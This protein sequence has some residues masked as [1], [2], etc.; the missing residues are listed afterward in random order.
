MRYH[1]YAAGYGYGPLIRAY[2]QYL[3][4]KLEFHRI[5]PEFNGKFDYHEYISNKGVSNLDEG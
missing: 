5:H 3:K 2:V 1:A 4:A